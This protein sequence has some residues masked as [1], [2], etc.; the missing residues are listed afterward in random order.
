M[1]FYLFGHG[2]YEKALN[3][4]LGMTGQGLLLAVAPEFFSWSQ[5][6]QLAHLDER[7]AEYLADQDHCR[8]TRELS[9]VPLLGIPGWCTDNQ[10]ESYYDNTDY[11]RPGRRG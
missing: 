4:Y 9:P 7:V 2:L 11:F 8:T 5:A 6:A 3:P 1:G 10:S